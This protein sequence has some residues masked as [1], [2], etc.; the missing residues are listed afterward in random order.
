MSKGRL[1]AFTDGVVAIIITI[2]VLDMKASVGRKSAAPSAVNISLFDISTAV[3]IR[4][5]SKTVG[6]LHS[7]LRLVAIARRQ[8]RNALRFSSLLSDCSS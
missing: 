2:M 1:E 6:W 3:V 7:G 5:S 4:G 8:W